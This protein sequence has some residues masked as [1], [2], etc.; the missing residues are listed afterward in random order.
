MDDILNYVMDCLN[1]SIPKPNKLPLSVL[2][3]TFCKVRPKDWLRTQMTHDATSEDGGEEEEE[4]S[5][6]ESMVPTESDPEWAPSGKLVPQK[7]SRHSLPRKSKH[8]KR[9]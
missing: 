2:S 6:D 3:S 8:S 9:K 4:D 7:R 5:F 1:I